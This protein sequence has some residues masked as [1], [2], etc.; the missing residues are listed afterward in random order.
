MKIRD[1]DMPEESYWE[2]LFDVP[3]IIRRFGMERFEDVLELGCGYGTFSIPLA[4]TI[5]G[6]LYTYDIDPKKV[7]RTEQRGKG[8]RLNC[9]VRDVVAHGFDRKADA[10]LLFNILHCEHPIDL[11]HHAASA[12][13]S[14]GEVLVIHWR[15]DIKTPR[16]PAADI[17]PTPQQIAD[18]AHAVGLQSG[19]TMEMAP[20]HYGLTLSRAN[21]KRSRD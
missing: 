20:W 3:H 2:S 1:S 16:G 12:L 8:L 9:Q 14:A 13:N 19:P 7:E 15:T 11:L 5:R 6:T 21:H 18:W 17:R 10:V 4:K